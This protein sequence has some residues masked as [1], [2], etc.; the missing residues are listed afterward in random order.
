MSSSAC[1]PPGRRPP[2]WK[3]WLAIACTCCRCAC[4]RPVIAFDTLVDASRSM[5]MDAYDHQAITFGELLRAL[6][7]PRD[8]SR[9]PLMSVMFNIDQA[10]SGEHAATPGVELELASNPRTFE[11]F[12]V[13]VNA[14][15]LGVGGMRLECQYNADLFDAA[16]ARALDGM[17]RNPAARR[18]PGPHRGSRCAA[19]A[20]RPRSLPA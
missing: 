14:V 4:V 7:L 8:R 3:D 19:V 20:R 9:L 16:H 10:L 11:T 12:E 15:D 18:H 13:F 1:R 5:L 17:F 6:P 2:G